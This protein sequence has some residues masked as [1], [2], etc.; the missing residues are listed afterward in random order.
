M[1]KCMEFADTLPATPHFSF[2][3]YTSIIKN[4]LLENIFFQS[5]GHCTMRHLFFAV[6]IAVFSLAQRG[7]AGAVPGSNAP[8]ASEAQPRAIGQLFPGA[9]KVSKAKYEVTSLTGTQKFKSSDAKALTQSQFQAAGWFFDNL[10][11]C[12]WVPDQS[13]FVTFAGTY[14]ANGKGVIVANLSHNSSSP[15]FAAQGIM[16]ATLTPKGK[17]Y[18]AKIDYAITATSPGSRVVHQAKLTQILLLP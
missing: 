7:P 10:G 18:L 4:A 3:S 8:D 9:A 14:N 6:L 1:R 11:N 15:N 16:S 13:K 2:A 17:Q 5:K 12:L